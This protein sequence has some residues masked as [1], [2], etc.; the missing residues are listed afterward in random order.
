[1]MPYDTYRLHQGERARSRAEI[2]RADQQAARLASAGS[3]LLRA[4][5]RSP[6][7]AGRPYP[8]TGHAGAP[9]LTEPAACPTTMAG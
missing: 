4:L 8:A 9:R 6:R 5:T 2:Q 3:R 7:A 1:M